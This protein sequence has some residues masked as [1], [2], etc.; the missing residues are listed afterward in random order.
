MIVGGLV[1]KFEV[2]SYVGRGG[3][4][5][6]RVSLESACHKDRFHLTYWSLVMGSIS[7]YMLCYTAPHHSFVAER[8]LV[9][10]G[11]ASSKMFVS[12]LA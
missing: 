9:D 12:L 3:R 11:A 5:A 6:W 7:P 1:E 8:T 10:G 2:E 4:C